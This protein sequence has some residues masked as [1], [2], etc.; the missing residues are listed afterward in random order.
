MTAQPQRRD[1]RPEPTER[2]EDL[3]ARRF[4]RTDARGDSEW[5]P[6]MLPPCLLVPEPTPLLLLALVGRHALDLLLVPGAEVRIAEVVAGGLPPGW[7][8]GHAGRVGLQRTP[9]RCDRKGSGMDRR[10]VLDAVA[11]ASSGGR[12]VFAIADDRDARDAIQTRDMPGVRLLSTRGFLRWVAV[13]FGVSSA[14][15]ARSEISCVLGSAG[16]A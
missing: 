3:H 14:S 9:P 1:D 5:G 2:P 13:A 15:A 8:A 11:A 10:V 16:R 6:G 12:G 7:L 4:G